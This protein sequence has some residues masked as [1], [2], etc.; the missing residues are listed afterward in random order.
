[1]KYTHTPDMG[2]ISG[3]GS[4]YEEACQT[5]LNAGVE[6]IMAHPDVKL[7]WQE[8]QGVYGWVQA[9]DDLTQE[10]ETVVVKS[11]GKEG[12]TG[13][14]MHAVAAR[15]MLV[16]R[17]GWEAYCE[18]CREASRVNGGEDQVSPK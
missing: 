1:M 17:D 2:E 18:G 4:T 16:A 15:L 9:K 6:W 7:V 10:L 12:P 5:M 11:L 13:A 3:F 8:M 14:M